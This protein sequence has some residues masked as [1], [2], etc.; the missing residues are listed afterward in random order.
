MSPAIRGVSTIVLNA[1]SRCA[2]SPSK[3]HSPTSW[4]RLPLRAVSLGA[5]ERHSLYSAVYWYQSADRIT[6]DYATRIWAD[7]SP[8]RE[9]WVLVSVLS[10]RCGRSAPPELAFY[11]IPGANPSR[12]LDAE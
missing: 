12:T 6:D 5:G 11:E 8:V 10:G 7:L 3:T 9:R 1:V 4:A 2:D